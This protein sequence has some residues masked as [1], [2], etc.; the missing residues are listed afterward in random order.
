MSVTA[1]R[2]R[3]ARTADIASVLVLRDRIALELLQRGQL[4]WDPSRITSADLVDLIDRDALFVAG[5]VV[6]TISVRFDDDPLWLSGRAG[7]IRM[8]MVEPASQATGL[9]S[10]LVSWACRFIFATGRD[11][12]RLDC[13]DGATGLKRFY[14]ELAFK[15]LEASNG[16][17][18][19]EKSRDGR[20]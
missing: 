10:H 1:T 11:L 8:L 14:E 12:V 18:L 20:I 9:G 2:I 6:G 15:Q 13:P 17:A 7:Y 3:Y 4:H 16:V 19:F 5:D